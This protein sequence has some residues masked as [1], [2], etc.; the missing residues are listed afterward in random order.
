[1]KISNKKLQGIML[2]VVGL[3]VLIKGRLSL[4]PGVFLDLSEYK[5][6][7][8]FVFLLIGFYLFLDKK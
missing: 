5:E 3:L 7:I 8:S 2:L 6:I 1:M 4:Y